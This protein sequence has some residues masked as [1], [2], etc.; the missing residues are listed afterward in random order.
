MYNVALLRVV[1]VVVVVCAIVVSVVMN[2]YGVAGPQTRASAAWPGRYHF[3][4][5][6]SD[7]E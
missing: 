1:S 7:E 3:P 5:P 2:R 6:W 4:S